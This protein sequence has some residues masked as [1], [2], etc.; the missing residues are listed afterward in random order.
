MVGDWDYWGHNNIEIDKYQLTFV[1]YMSS[2]P[3]LIINRKLFMSWS[4]VRTDQVYENTLSNN[5]NYFIIC[6]NKSICEVLVKI[7]VA[8]HT[9]D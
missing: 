3:T 7:T 9:H 4:Y 8:W 2:L 6:N 5:Y 1:A